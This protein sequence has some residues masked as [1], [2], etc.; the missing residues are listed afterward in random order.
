MVTDNNNAKSGLDDK[1]T[2]SGVDDKDHENSNGESQTGDN[3]TPATRWP[4]RQATLAA[5]QRDG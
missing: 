3:L 4:V 2:E 1:D 5:R